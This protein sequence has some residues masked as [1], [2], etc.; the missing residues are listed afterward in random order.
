MSW[1]EISDS[2]KAGLYDRGKSPFYGSFIISWLGWN[3]RLVFS[4]FGDGKQDF[5]ARITIINEHYVCWLNNLIFP[6]GTAI[7]IFVLGNFLTSF[8]LRIKYLF[9]NYRRKKIQKLDL[10][11]EIQTEKL[12]GKIEKK[13]IE[14]NR[15]LTDKI[16]EIESYKSI[17]QELTAKISI[18]EKEQIELKQNSLNQDKNSEVLV[19]KLNEKLVS[20]SNLQKEIKDYKSSHALNIKE[21]EKLKIEL[22][23]Y[24]LHIN[25]SS[26][27]L[28]LHSGWQHKDIDENYLV[29]NSSTFHA[30]IILNNIGQT[31][32]I[33]FRLVVNGNKYWVGFNFGKE[34]S[35]HSVKNEYTTTKVH[36]SKEIIIEENIVA[37][38]NKGFPNLK[39]SS[40]KIDCIRLRADKNDLSDIIFNYKVESSP[41]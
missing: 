6:L 41:F 29:D 33:Y 24:Q 31:C 17:N 20:I 39:T 27:R 32:T 12:W 26:S 23:K 28:Y 14:I 5:A 7:L 19:T 22:N 8:F 37:I 1:D 35:T 34:E 16:A 40:L 30:R 15:M 38:V 11:D 36:K 4:L 3:W 9:S 10:L 2:L 21:I 13:E 18:I 25:P